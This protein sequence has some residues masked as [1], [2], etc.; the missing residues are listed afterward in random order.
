MRK[1]FFLFF[2]LAGIIA[3]GCSQQNSSQVQDTLQKGILKC[4]KLLDSN[5]K[6]SCY[7]ELTSKSKDISFC[8]NVKSEDLKWTCYNSIVPTKVS[9]ANCGALQNQETRDYCHFH[10]SRESQEHNKC[11]NIQNI[12]IKDECFLYFGLEK[13]ESFICDNIQ[14]DEP[15]DYCYNEVILSKN[16]D[17]ALSKDDVSVCSRIKDQSTRYDCYITIAIGLKDQYICLNIHEKDEREFCV[18]RSS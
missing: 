11:F 8:E 6:D 15:R 5:E 16:V 3:F 7:Y 10:A 18:S 14:S 13:K 9:L 17:N 4:G 2:I 1:L 12:T